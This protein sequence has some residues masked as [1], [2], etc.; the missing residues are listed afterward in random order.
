MSR[1]LRQEDPQGFGSQAVNP[2]ILPIGVGAVTM[3]SAVWGPRLWSRVCGWEEAR[4][5]AGG[6][7]TRLQEAGR[8][9][10]RRAAAVWRDHSEAT[11]ANP[12][13][14]LNRNRNRLCFLT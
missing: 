13:D 12:E 4:P 7:G 14:S 1:L 11:A 10:L 3:G 9:A 2:A 6:L 8:G 5:E